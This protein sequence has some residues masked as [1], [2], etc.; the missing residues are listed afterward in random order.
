M[1]IAT[2]T[3]TSLLVVTAVAT[4][5]PIR[6]SRSEHKTQFDRLLQ[7]HDRKAELRAE[8]LGVDPLTFRAEQKQ[9]SMEQLVHRYG[10]KDMR[11]FRLALLGKIKQELHARGWS[12]RRIEQFLTRRSSRLV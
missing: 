1:R 7:R 5:L 9:Y 8:L 11:Q 2:K 10:F 3:L 6:R 4:R 12:A